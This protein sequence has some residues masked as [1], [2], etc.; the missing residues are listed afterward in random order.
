MIV[1][2][3]GPRSKAARAAIDW[4]L[5]RL[6]SNRSGV[7]KNV[8]SKVR[9]VRLDGPVTEA[10]GACI[11][12]RCASLSKSA[13]TA[14]TPAS[15][16]D[17]PASAGVDRA[18]LAASDARAPTETPFVR[19]FGNPHGRFVTLVSLGLDLRRGNKGKCA[20]WALA[21]LKHSRHPVPAHHGYNS[22]SQT[23]TIRVAPVAETLRG[24]PS[25]AKRKRS[26]SGGA[27]CSRQ[28]PG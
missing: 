22:R 8:R 28:L 16:C 13:T 4:T 25:D 1:R 23:E 27:L 10:P 26:G 17:P 21:G 3:G 24:A 14:G 12:T 2:V 18:R 9:F 7:R 15:P 6:F 19:C 11:H 5:P 20:G